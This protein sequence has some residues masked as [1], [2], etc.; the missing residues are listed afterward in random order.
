MS[1]LKRKNEEQ[2]LS[3]DQKFVI[4]EVFFVC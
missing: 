4:T 1:E 2:S 3:F